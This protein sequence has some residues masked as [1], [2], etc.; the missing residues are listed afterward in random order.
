MRAPLALRNIALFCRPWL[1]RNRV[2]V[3]ELL[4]IGTIGIFF[5]SKSFVFGL[6]VRW[7]KFQSQLLIIDR[8]S[9]G[10]LLFWL[11]W[12]AGTLAFVTLSCICSLIQWLKQWFISRIILSRF[13][14]RLG[15]LLLK[16]CSAVHGILMQHFLYAP[17]WLV[18]K[19]MHTC[20]SFVRHSRLPVTFQTGSHSPDWPSF[21][22]LAVMQSTC[23]ALPQLWP[24]GSRYEGS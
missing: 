7:I 13:P 23:A 15:A 12:T 2:N 9:W 24:C 14:R 20:P 17:V 8:N 4:S 11:R 3:L 18:M 19:L 22:W 10:R 16:I 1:V 6:G 21:T 5:P